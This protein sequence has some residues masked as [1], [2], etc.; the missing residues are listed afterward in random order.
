MEC[1]WFWI[2]EHLQANLAAVFL[3]EAAAEAMDI[4]WP[5]ECVHHAPERPGSDGSMLSETTKLY[6]PSVA[7]IVFGGMN[8]GKLNTLC[9]QQGIT[10]SWY[11]WQFARVDAR[12]VCFRANEKA[13]FGFGR[14]HPTKPNFKT[15]QDY[16][17]PLRD[18]CPEMAGIPEEWKGFEPVFM[19]VEP[20]ESPRTTYTLKIHPEWKDG[21]VLLIVDESPEDVPEMLQNYE[22]GRKKKAVNQTRF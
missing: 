2:S 15:H 6:V 5:E 13:F 19:K 22:F 1:R 11:E 21:E 10:P 17:G 9:A 4:P 16:A 14:P 12:V 3:G 20:A 18:Y 7:P 8:L